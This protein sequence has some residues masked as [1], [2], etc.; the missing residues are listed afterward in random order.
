MKITH[1]AG[2]YLAECRCG[3]LRW[4]T[5]QAQVEQAAMKH[6]EKCGEAS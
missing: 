6:A 5:H 3:W 4:G 2:G 1:E